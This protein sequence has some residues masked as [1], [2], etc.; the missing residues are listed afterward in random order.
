MERGPIPI[1]EKEQQLALLEELITSFEVGEMDHEQLMARLAESHPK[2]QLA[3]LKAAVLTLN[4]EFPLISGATR[5]DTRRVDRNIIE[6]AKKKA[7]EGNLR[8]LDLEIFLPRDESDK[9]TENSWE[10]GVYLL[11]SGE[12]SFLYLDKDEET[13]RQAE[14]PPK[15]VTTRTHPNLRQGKGSLPIHALQ[16]LHEFIAAS[17]PSRVQS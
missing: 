15:F 11:P 10:L 6:E 2:L 3:Q 1:E 4:V 17:I 14:I 7:Y 5:L 13:I 12:L 9:A 8:G 16:K